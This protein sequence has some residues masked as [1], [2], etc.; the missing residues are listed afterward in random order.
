MIAGNAVWGQFCL[1]V[2]MRATPTI[3]VYGTWAVTNTGQPTI[4]GASASSFLVQIVATTTGIATTFPN[5]S[6]DIIDASI[7]L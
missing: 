4:R 3:T 7:E 6:D 2:T 5:S 1:P